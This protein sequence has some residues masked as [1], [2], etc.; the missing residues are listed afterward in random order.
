MDL[1]REFIS[2]IHNAM[3]EYDNEKDIQK[4]ALLGLE[5]D[6]LAFMLSPAQC[7]QVARSY[8]H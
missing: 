2:K 4:M 5:L 6:K 3:L 8:A 7:S 1:N